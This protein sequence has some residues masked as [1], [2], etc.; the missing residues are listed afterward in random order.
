MKAVIRYCA[1]FSSQMMTLNFPNNIIKKVLLSFYKIKK[2]K[3]KDIKELAPGSL[4]T[5]V[6]C[7]TGLRSL[8]IYYSAQLPPGKRGKSDK[9]VK[10]TWATH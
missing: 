5:G 9:L 1:V 2:L 8:L 10:H 7:S 4:R 3:F 6:Q